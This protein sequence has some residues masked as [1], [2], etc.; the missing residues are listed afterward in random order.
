MLRRTRV[1][2]ELNYGKPAGQR[3]N[4]KRVASVMKA[5]GLAEIWLRRRIRTTVP[6]LSDQKAPDLLERDFTA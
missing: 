4:H 6:E 3:F 5:H 2:A 1:T